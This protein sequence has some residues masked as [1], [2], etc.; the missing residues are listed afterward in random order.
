MQNERVAHERYMA[1]YQV[2]LNI[3]NVLSQARIGVVDGKAQL[4]R[5]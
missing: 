5:L 3:K 2:Q 1:Q 4:A